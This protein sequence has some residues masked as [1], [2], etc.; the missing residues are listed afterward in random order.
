MNESKP[1]YASSGV[2]G[3]VIAVLAAVL[4]LLGYSIGAEDQ[5][6]LAGYVATIGSVVGG[7]LAII[8]RVRAS[9]KIG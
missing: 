9:K 7:L 3:G 1:W 8:G 5:V 6:A 4:G 2:W